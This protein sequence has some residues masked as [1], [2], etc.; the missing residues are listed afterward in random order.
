M[1][2]IHRNVTLQDIDDTKNNII[3]KYKLCCNENLKDIIK[4]RYY[5]AVVKISTKLSPSFN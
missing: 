1:F 2:G 4:L 3:S 5:E